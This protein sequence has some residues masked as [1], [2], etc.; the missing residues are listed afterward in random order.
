MVVKKFNY[1]RFISVI[2]GL[3]AIL[4]VIIFGIV[5]LVKHINY[6]K[7]Y[8][9]K[10]EQIGYNESEIKVIK[11]KLK[12]EYIDKILKQKYNSELSELL[13]EKYFIFDNM[14]K[15][16]EYK[17]ENDD[18][19]YTKVIAI[20]NSEANIEWMDNE[21]D[22][23]ISKNE[24]MLVNRIY[25]LSKDYEPEDIIDVPSKY[26]YSG[27]KISESIMEDIISLISA[28]K[29]AGYTFVVSDGYRSYSEQEKIYNSYVSSYGQSEADEIVARPGH[30]EYQT[31]LSFDLMPYNKVYEDPK[32]SEEY[33]WLKDNAYKYGF[34]FRYETGK[35]DLTGFK[36]STWR[37]RYVGVSAATLIYNE[38]ITFEEYYAYFVK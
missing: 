30:S 29:E 13:K 35:E 18:D 33:L 3:I 16:I 9:Y 19:D 23:D 8:D 27:K 14:D 24:L 37:L 2:V 17:K 20:I 5:S 34:I 10:L 15:Y 25:G 21:R 22:A 26:A 7:T 6:T 1:V 11:S 12:D 4:G 28:G 31:G 38:N 36:A 32:I